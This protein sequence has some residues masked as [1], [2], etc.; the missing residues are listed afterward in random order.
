MLTQDNFHMMLGVIW[1]IAPL[2]AIV[3]RKKPYAFNA[4]LLGIVA[5]GFFGGNGFMVWWFAAIGWAIWGR[6]LGGKN[7]K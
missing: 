6:K 4:G 5:A 3:I 1:M 7:A 2:I